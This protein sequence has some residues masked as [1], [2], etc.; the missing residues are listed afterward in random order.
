MKNLLLTVIVLSVI[1]N[2]NAQSVGYHGKKN[3][4]SFEAKLS[5]PILYM[6]NSFEF[7][8]FNLDK[9]VNI[10]YGRILNRNFAIHVN[11]ESWYYKF[12]ING[13]GTFMRSADGNGYGKVMDCDGISA[14]RKMIMPVFE[15][16]SGS[17]SLPAGVAFQFGV[18]YGKT[19][20]DPSYSEVEMRYEVDKSDYYNMTGD[21]YYYV[22]YKGSEIYDKTSEP[23]RMFSFMAKPVYRLPISEFLLFNI[24]YSYSLNFTTEWDEIP[25]LSS[26]KSPDTES[27]MSRDNMRDEIHFR[28][29]RSFSAISMGFTLAL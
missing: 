7:D 4:I 14:N 5:Y 23:I 21:D 26:P 6:L 9:A 8:Y 12:V 27:L 20:V 15:W 22:N 18:G 24:G 10:S 25:F 17:G 11:Y 13:E 16:I 2:L 1:G 28:E 19:S 29:L 3:L